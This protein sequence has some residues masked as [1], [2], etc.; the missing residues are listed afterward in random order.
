MEQLASTCEVLG[1]SKPTLHI[2][3]LRFVFLRFLFLFFSN[4]KASAW[5][6]F[7]KEVRM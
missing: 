6:S 2:L 1:K 4:A 3:L 7:R 5:N